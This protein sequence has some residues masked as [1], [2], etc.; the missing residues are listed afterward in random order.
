MKHILDLAHLALLAV[1]VWTAADFA[2]RVCAIMTSQNATTTVTV[3]SWVDKPSTG[4]QD[5]FTPRDN[6]EP[7]R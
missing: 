7:I 4:K 3:D 5:K 1:L 2:D 6:K